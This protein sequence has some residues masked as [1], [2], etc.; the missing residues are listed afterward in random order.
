MEKYTISKIDGKTYCVINGSFT[1]H[2]RQHG[3]TFQEYYEK[4]VTLKTELCPFCDSKRKL[5][6]HDCSYT[7]TCGKTECVSKQVKFTKSLWSNEQKEK[8]RTNKRLAALNVDKEQKKKK[9]QETYLKKYG[10]THPWKCSDIREKTKR[11]KKEK[12]GHEFYSNWESSSEKNKSKSPEEKG[13]INN[14]RAETNLG[15]YGVTNTFMLPGIFKK[16]RVNNSAVKEY[17]LPSGKVIG[18]RGYENIVIDFL[19][20][21]GY[22]EADLVIHDD[23]SEYTIDIFEYK[24]TQRKIQRYYPDIYIPSE[25]KIIEVKSQ[26][27]YDGYGESKYSPDLKI[28]LLKEMQLSRRGLHTNYG[29]LNQRTSL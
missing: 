20:N 1:K 26:W 8:D 7:A 10:T 29:Y 24:T 4:F 21:S 25:N 5:N 23:F 18:I 6:M 27:W 14:K 11:T 13:I 16:T 15:L 12:Y 19:L 22:K 3:Y 9:S 28:I 2:L 17:T